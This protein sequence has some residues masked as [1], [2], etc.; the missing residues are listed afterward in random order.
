[1]TDCPE[2][3]RLRGES[4][5][6][7]AEYEAHKDELAMTRKADKAFD[8]KRRA[9]EQARGRL[10]ECHNREHQHRT[11]AHSGYGSSME[12]NSIE[13]KFRRLRESLL[14][15]DAEGVQ[16]T[17]FDLSPVHN[18]WATVPDEV[19]ERLLTLLRRDEVYKSHLAGH[20]LNYFEFES[21]RLS[22]HQKWLC[23]GFLNAHGDKF[24][25]VHSRQ[26]VTEL[27]AGDYL[28]GGAA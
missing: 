6:A 22:G 23:I 8:S 11:E 10:R 27:R 13:E 15:G 1:M 7:F 17:I 12:L 3:A 14:V 19:V 25:D 20:V 4:G 21:P 16:Q 5:S 9:F 28:A 18:G 26:V 2:C 24:T